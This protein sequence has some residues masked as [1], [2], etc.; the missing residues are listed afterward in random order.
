MA[1]QALLED[2]TILRLVWRSH[3]IGKTVIKMSLEVRLVRAHLAFRVRRDGRELEFV[4]LARYGGFEVRL[5]E[6]EKSFRDS[7]LEFWL[8]LFDLHRK[9][10]VDSGGANDLEQALE[11]AE[12][13]VLRAKE[14]NH[15]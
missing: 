11:I 2:S 9:I 13:F 5:V 4:S 1:S 10:S 7:G 14:L 3:E 8:E 15:E 6:P 12:E